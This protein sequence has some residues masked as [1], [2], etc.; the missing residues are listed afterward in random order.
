LLSNILIPV[1]VFS[2]TVSN[3]NCTKINSLTDEQFLEWFRGLV[4]GEGSFSIIPIKN[5]FSFRFSIYMHK[6]DAPMLEVVALRL[7]V[8]H[9]NIGNHFVS[10]YVT[11]KDDIVSILRIFDR[12]PLNT[13]KNLNYLMWKKGYELYNRKTSR[14]ISSEVAK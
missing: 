3:S 14:Q 11:S 5:Y 2:N 9:I 4:D 7:K 1:P 12:F 6:D 8:G 10:Y 13:S